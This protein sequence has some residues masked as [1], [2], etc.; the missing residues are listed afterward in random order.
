MKI[1]NDSITGETTISCT[2][3]LK[4]GE[5]VLNWNSSGFDT[6]SSIKIQSKSDTTI[7]LI[8]AEVRNL[9]NEYPE[10]LSIPDT[11]IIEFK[12]RFIFNS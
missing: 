6:K 10:L 3:S 9:R 5:L 11:L 1:N 12:N 8:G 7:T 4:K 2:N